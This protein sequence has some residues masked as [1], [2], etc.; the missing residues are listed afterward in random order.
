MADSSTVCAEIVCD[1]ATFSFFSGSGA[2]DSQIA[3]S[4]AWRMASIAWR[5]YEL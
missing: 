2:T 5:R 3:R 1:Q 4:G